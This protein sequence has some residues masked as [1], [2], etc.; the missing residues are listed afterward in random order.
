MAITES[1]PLVLGANAVVISGLAGL[2]WASVHPR[3]RFWGPIYCRAT[4]EAAGAACA[5]TFD[6]GPTPGSTERVLDL[7]G[8]LNVRAAFFVIGRNVE[9]A[10]HLLRRMHDEGH[11]IGNHSYHHH[12]LAMFRGHAY[13][14]AEVHRTNELIWQIIG[15]RPAMFRPPLGV[16]TWFINHAAWAADQRIVTWS[17]RSMDGVANTSKRIV[18]RVLPQ[19]QPGDILLFHDGVEPGRQRDIGPT[20]AALGPTIM[21]LRQRGIEPRRLDELLGLHAYVVGATG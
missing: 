9:T 20:V 12:R 21:G 18:E 13:W 11:L 1:L 8:E 10:P 14:T 5:I 19:T 16:K 7:L 3:S 6:D 15:Q 4:G 17:V 2:V